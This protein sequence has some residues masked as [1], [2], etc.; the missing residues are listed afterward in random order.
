MKSQNLTPA[1]E[2]ETIGYNYYSQTKSW[3]GFIVKWDMQRK[4][5]WMFNFVHVHGYFVAKIIYLLEECMEQ[6]YLCKCCSHSK[7]S[8][9]PRCNSQTTHYLSGVPL[10]RYISSHIP[11]NLMM[12]RYQDSFQYL[13]FES[14]GP[15]PLKGM[16]YRHVFSDRAFYC[17][18]LVFHQGTQ[19][20]P[21]DLGSIL[22]LGSL[23][24][25]WCTF[26]KVH[27][28]LQMFKLNNAQKWGFV[29]ISNKVTI[30]LWTELYEYLVLFMFN[31]F[32]TSTLA[33]RAW[34]D[35]SVYYMFLSLGESFWYNFCL[36]SFKT[37]RR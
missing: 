11:S 2:S 34:G 31:S 12:L 23:S 37:F 1:P 27:N 10:E 14:F 32:S 29:P 33:A 22:G 4:A 15:P 26:E 36:K 24:F 8:Q 35:F 25:V 30:K 28:W 5:I 20:D 21:N 3:G 19:W 7:R 16:V 6:D 9:G 18:G 13:M 17:A